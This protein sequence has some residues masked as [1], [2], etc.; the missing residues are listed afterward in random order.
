MRCANQSD[1]CADVCYNERGRHLASPQCASGGGEV[2][3]LM[4]LIVTQILTPRKRPDL[5]HRDRLVDFFHEHVDRK[6]LLVSAPAGYGKTSL[7]VDYAHDTELTVCW[8]SVVDS[9]RDPRVLLD[10][11]VACIRYHFPQFGARSR[12]VIRS[13]E[14]LTDC[15]LV[16]ATIVNE[17]YETIPDY[18]VVVIDDFHLVDSSQ[19]VN[20]MVDAIV[21]HLPE[22]C[23]I[24]LSSRT[25]PTLTVRGLALLT[26]RQQI[27]GLGANDLRFTGPEIQSLLEQNYGQT[28]PI[29]L[30]NELADRSEGWI[31][32]IVL[33]TRAMWKG[34]FHNMVC[35]RGSDS[36]VY[37]YLVNEVFAQQPL[38]V[39][40]FLLSTSVLEEMSPLLC[41]QVLNVTNS[42]EILKRLEDGNLF[43]SRLERGDERWYRYHQLFRQFL[44]AKLREDHPQWVRLLQRRAGEVLRESGAFEEAIACFIRAEDYDAAMES[45]MEVA[46]DTY[47]AGR[48]AVLSGWIDSLP[49]DMVRGQPRLQW[50]RAKIHLEVSELNQATL[51]FREAFDGFSSSGDRLGQAQALVEESAV[52]RFRGDLRRAIDACERALILLG[53]DTVEHDRVRTIASAYRQIGTCQASLGDLASG[54]QHLRRALHIYEDLGY[55]TNVAYVHL[56]LGAILQMSGDLVGAKLHFHQALEIWERLGNVGL[57][58]L[59]LNNIAIGHYYRG[60]YAEA[61]R[62]YSL[63]LEQAKRVALQRPMAFILA[64]MGDVQ[65]DQAAYAAAL[66]SYEEGLR[67]ARQ[68]RESY[69]LCYLLDAIGNTYRLMGQEIRAAD[70]VRQAHSRARERDAKYEIA[71]YETTLGAIH[72]Q[73]GNLRQAADYLSQAQQVFQH[74]SARRELARASLLLAQTRYVEGRFHE[75]WAC[76]EVVA[77]CLVE[78]GY[79]QFL[80]SV[81]REAR[82]VLARAVDRDVGGSVIKGLL[83]KAATDPAPDR[84]VVPQE[85]SP[86]PLLRVCAFGQSRAFRGEETVT[87]AEWGMAKSKELLFYL[88]T[89]GPRRKDQIGTDLWPDLSSAKLRSSF[90]VAIY[91][92][93]RAL[94]QQDCVLFEGDQYLFNRRINFWYDVDE[95]ES[96][97]E[98]G[99]AS[100]ET[101]RDRAAQHLNHAFVLYVGDFLDDMASA[102]DWCLAKRQELEDKYLKALGLLGEYHLL[103]GRPA[104][105]AEFFERTLATDAYRESAYRGLMRCQVLLGN[106]SEALRSYRRLAELFAQELGAVPAHKS[107]ALYESILH[108]AE[109]ASEDD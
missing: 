38:E 13:A 34:I 100:W 75:A 14:S 56:D 64:G 53:E 98:A 52:L 6:L 95:F 11:M 73:Q 24:I 69:I 54:E 83:D 88:L 3:T 23:H 78:L 51:L 45:I 70:Y 26:A 65:R 92:L 87:A 18:F 37:D 62:L 58:A 76:L 90:H 55:S 49:A 77:G 30:A 9:C 94:G 81:A 16:A 8:L 4:P 48:F 59:T 10:Y 7:L 39:Q 97:M 84:M 32:G 2:T 36:K 61:L 31:T 46:R 66:A 33:T 28:V 57:T 42:R 96:H 47:D 63:A 107:K 72:Y 71:L 86:Q 104:E 99:I 35:L 91:R 21:Q 105:A 19:A 43:I 93:R 109:L 29:D 22:N 44:L 89:F 82:L 17:I 27:A 5:L 79:D 60:E 101:D 68:T 1:F 50:F 12:E 25:V 103:A 106:R 85:A 67:A 102:H 41:D 40:Q 80:V 15:E 74:S 20:V 108:S